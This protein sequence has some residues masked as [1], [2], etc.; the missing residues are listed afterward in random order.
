[1]RIPLILLK[2][3]A[4]AYLNSLTGGLAGEFV[5]GIAEDVMKAWQRDCDE[6]ARKAELEVIAQAGTVEVKEAV[7]EVVSEVA[8]GRSD[9]D[10]RALTSYMLQVPASIRR[11][12][13]RPSDPSGRT[14]PQGLVV[15]TAL[16][17]APLLPN[18]LPR[19]QP[20]DRPLAGVD[21]EL[22][23]LLGVGG[24]G[25]VWKAVNPNRPSVSPVALK[26]CIDP[27]ARDRLLRHEARMLD[28][29]MRVGALSGVVALRDTYLNAD[30]PCLEYEYVGGGELTGLILDY[31]RSRGGFPTKGSAR[32][33]ERLARTVG[34]FHRLD[35]PIVHRDLKPANI[36]VTTDDQW[37]MGLK[38]ADFGIGGIAAGREIE[39]SQTSR[40]RG[41]PSSSISHGSYTP[42]YASP[43]QARGAPPD[44]RDDVH[45]LGVVWFQLLTGDLSHG[46][47]TGLDWTDDLEAKGMTREQ[48]NLLGSCFSSR[49]ERRP[50]DASV[51]A[52]RIDAV[53][54]LREKRAEVTASG[55]ASETSRP[56]TLTA[57]AEQSVSAPVG[58][59]GS[60]GQGTEPS[61]I[62]PPEGASGGLPPPNSPGDADE[63]TESEQGGSVEKDTHDPEDGT[64]TIRDTGQGVSLDT[65]DDVRRFLGFE[66]A[67]GLVIG[68]LIRAAVRGLG[69]GTSSDPALSVNWRGRKSLSVTCGEANVLS[70]EQH[71]S[72]FEVWVVLPDGDVDRID[73]PRGVGVETFPGGYEA[74][75]LVRLGTGQTP[76]LTD[77]ESGL[78]AKGLSLAGEVARG[79]TNPWRGHRSF[80]GGRWLADLCLEQPGAPLTSASQPVTRPGVSPPD[81]ENGSG[82]SLN[83]IGME[84]A[85]IP[86]GSFLMGDKASWLPDV[87]PLHEV[88]VSRPFFLA[89]HPVSR[90]EFRA[91][92]GKL[93]NRTK[94]EDTDP[95]KKV[96][97]FDAVRFCNRLS[98]KE[99]LNAF[100]EIDD[101]PEPRVT[102][103]D[104][105]GEGYRLPTEAEWEYAY[106]GGWSTPTFPNDKEVEPTGEDEED[107][108]DGGGRDEL[109]GMTEENDFGVKYMNEYALEWCWDR[110]SPGYYEKSPR[111]DPTGETSEY[112]PLRVCRGAGRGLRG[113]CLPGKPREEA[114]FRVARTS[115]SQTSVSHQPGSANTPRFTARGS[116]ERF[117]KD[118]WNV[119]VRNVDEIV[120]FWDLHG[121]KTRLDWAGMDPP[122]AT[123]GRKPLVA[124]CNAAGEGVE[125]EY[126]ME[127]QDRANGRGVTGVDLRVVAPIQSEGERRPAD[128]SVSTPLER[129]AGTLEGGI[130]FDEAIARLVL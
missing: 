75:R 98:V 32:I 2:H 10:R 103:P 85:L 42:L 35:P 1:M 105:G 113:K 71:G 66:K 125:V 9:Q 96:T 77:E 3:V 84:L 7:A 82:V 62:E 55:P 54:H 4:K 102:V 40:S 83:S 129:D 27:A 90:G 39:R 15:K 22:V 107:S 48:I 92:M 18:R 116:L 8:P 127:V 72:S 57:P 17:L 86:A 130:S 88:T 29:V 28:R 30:P 120:R 38:I 123:V 94:G 112:F 21:R 115:G 65:W 52:E 56:E 110:Y 76:A 104:W 20:G 19:F 67:S 70:V 78:W 12:L 119:L 36:L 128:P 63:Q 126:D 41:E 117:G 124:R 47:P 45:A 53:F 73:P 44:P 122:K 108:G 79:S 14:V 13:R 49:Q 23:E 114:G 97:W 25:E 111:V 100:Y 16:D 51:L 101:T 64:N 87:N 58:G 91:V 121:I 37:R 118:Q 5:F 89:L 26:F 95:L 33:V 24:F 109:F 46:A 68:E 6:P 106:Y 69:L 80:L 60:K 61:V 34:H 93:P 11:T 43:E 50:S 74:V 81:D 59:T 31:H 99:N